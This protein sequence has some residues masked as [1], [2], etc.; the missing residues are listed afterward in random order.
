MEI[1]QLRQ[2]RGMLAPGAPAEFYAVVHENIRHLE[3]G[4]TLAPKEQR[5][6]RDKERREEVNDDTWRQEAFKRLS[7]L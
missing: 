4:G 2:Q 7:E 3:Q 1:E 6:K 5:A